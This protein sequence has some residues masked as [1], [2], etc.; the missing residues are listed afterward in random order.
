MEMPLPDG[1]LVVETDKHIYY[2]GETISGNVHLL[3][4]ETIDDAKCLDIVLKGR[5]SFKYQT[6]RKRDE[7]SCRNYY[8]ILDHPTTIS[9]FLNKKVSPGQ[10]SFK[11]KIELPENNLPASF[12]QR[13]EIG[14]E[15]MLKAK[16]RYCVSAVIYRWSGD[17]S[18]S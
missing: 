8:T 2:P 1:G 4:N 5:E 10:Y 17:F 12:I 9:K 16:I 7:Q 13:Q 14:S 18:Q 6:A 15:G 3:I 11:F